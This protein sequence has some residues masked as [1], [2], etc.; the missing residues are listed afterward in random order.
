LI[1]ARKDGFCPSGLKVNES[2]CFEIAEA[3]IAREIDLNDIMPEI[4]AFSTR[5]RDHILSM[6][7]REQN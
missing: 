3:G 6:D 5:L 7:A 1:E 4:E 2:R